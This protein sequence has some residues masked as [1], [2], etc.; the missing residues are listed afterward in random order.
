MKVK[1]LK[2]IRKDWH[3][4]EDFD[5]LVRIKNDYSQ[6]YELKFTNSLTL[7]CVSYMYIGLNYYLNHNKKLTINKNKRK[8]K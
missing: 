3:V 7:F 5:H 6:V 8:Y 4:K 1:L 2:K